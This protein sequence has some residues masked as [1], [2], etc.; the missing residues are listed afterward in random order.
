MDFIPPQ[1]STELVVHTHVPFVF[2]LVVPV[3]EVL[4]FKNEWK[5][6]NAL[7][8]WLE[9]EKSS[10]KQNKN[11]NKQKK[12]QQKCRWSVTNVDFFF[13]PVIKNTLRTCS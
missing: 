6:D 7:H 5:S 4:L 3:C 12:E 9:K 13:F 10:F 8:Q 11:K 1:I 2:S